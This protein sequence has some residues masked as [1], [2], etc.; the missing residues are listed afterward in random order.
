MLTHDVVVQ[1]NV[2]KSST[3]KGWGRIAGRG[4]QTVAKHFGHDDEV[5]LRIEGASDAHH[6]FGV[7]VLPAIECWHDNDV[8]TCRVELSIGFLGKL[9]VVQGKSGLEPYV[10]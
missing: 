4:G 10:S 3:I 1:C 8:V 6:G 9:G 7:G 5:L 2:R